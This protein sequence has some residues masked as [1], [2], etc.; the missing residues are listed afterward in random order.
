MPTS[1]DAPSA[2]LDPQAF[3]SEVEA[4]RQALADPAQSQEELRRT[5]CRIVAHA[6]LL[7]PD[8]ARFAGLGVS[9]KSALCAWLDTHPIESES[10]R[11]AAP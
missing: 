1:A 10:G 5:L 4:F 9:L 7:D 2:G 8:D 3:L 6:S 11:S